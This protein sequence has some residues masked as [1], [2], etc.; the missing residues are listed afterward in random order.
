M[1]KREL[2]SLCW[3]L[4]EEDRDSWHEACIDIHYLGHLPDDQE[5]TTVKLRDAAW[6]RLRYEATLQAKDAQIEALV[7]ALRKAEW[8]DDELDHTADWTARWCPWCGDYEHHGH[9]KDCE[10]RAIIKEVTSD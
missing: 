4:D 7:T 8:V 9:G 6:V 3:P 5:K 2:P 1:K 10:Y